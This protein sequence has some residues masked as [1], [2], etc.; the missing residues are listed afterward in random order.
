[1]L[2]VLIA[3]TID[4]SKEAVN[5]LEQFAYVDLKDIGSDELEDALNLYDVFWFRLGFRLSADLILG[6]KKCQYI[7]CPATGLDHIDIEACQQKGI[8][9][10]SLKGETEFLKKVRATAELT[11][12]LTIALLRHI[13]QAIK[14]TKSGGW[15][16]TPYK[17][18]EIYEKNIGILGYGRLGQIM[19]TYYQAMG[20]NVYLYD[21]KPIQSTSFQV[22]GS[23]NELF[24]SCDIVSVH[25]NLTTE[26]KHLIS[27]TQF[28]LMKKGSY[29]VNTS[30]GQLVKSADLIQ[31]I[32]SG[33][34]AGAAVDVIEKEYDLEQ[35]ELLK[36]A[37]NDNRLL[38][39]PHI[40]GNTYESFSK[41]ELYMVEKL[42][43]FVV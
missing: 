40:G 39:T 3:E 26:N 19:G 14:H 13:P 35:D 20:A 30:R 32:E 29:F 37:A 23:M 27:S 31:A 15:S 21:I 43:S 36:W 42:K 25:A 9:V 7:I 41:T 24:Q 12:G 6:A 33:Q 17:G 38:I 8:N 28:N 4:F 16:R 1:M 11:L 22:L 2:R 34:L 5:A 18:L 10:I